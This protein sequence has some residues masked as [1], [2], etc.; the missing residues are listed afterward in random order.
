MN[1]NLN[2]MQRKEKLIY[3]KPNF[4]RNTPLSAGMKMKSKPA[5]FNLS[6]CKMHQAKSLSE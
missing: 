6:Q 4:N 3:C 5:P 1:N 2:D